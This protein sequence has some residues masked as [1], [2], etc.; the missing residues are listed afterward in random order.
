MAKEKTSFFNTTARK[1]RALRRSKII[2]ALSLMAQG[3]TF[4]VS[5][6]PVDRL[7]KWIAGLFLATCFA[8]ITSYF[9]SKEK[10][11]T[12]RITALASAVVGV[13]CIWVWLH[14]A[15]IAGALHYII[16]SLSILY[17]LIN[18]VQC[19]RMERKFNGQL[20]ISLIINVL[21]VGLGISIIAQPAATSA[22]LLK[23]VGGM[24][25]L[26]AVS[27]L[28]TAHRLKQVEKN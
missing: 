18:M 13:L 22:M 28:W 15:Q 10:T 6:G 23:I 7:T 11:G 8:Y 27:N 24:L 5:K 9:A 12:N 16:A 25:I 2:A 17:G 4:I 21:A 14:P 3:I 20:A 19:F 1:V 26:V